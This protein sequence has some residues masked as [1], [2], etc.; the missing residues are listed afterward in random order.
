MEDKFIEINVGG[1]LF[2][3]TYLT[4][5]ATSNYFRRLLDKDNKHK[6]FDMNGAIF[7]DKSPEY[8]TY[9]LSFLRSP[10]S[11]FDIKQF[12]IDNSSFISELEYYQLNTILK[13]KY[14]IFG[15]GEQKGVMN[16]ITSEIQAYYP[17][18]NQWIIINNFPS[19]IKRTGFV[20]N[21]NTA[22]FI[23]GYSGQKALS[24][25]Y[26]YEIDSNFLTK[27]GDL[28]VG[29]TYPKSKILE[30]KLYVV[31]GYISGQKI[32]SKNI[33]IYDLESKKCNIEYQISTEL[34]G[35]GF[36]IYNNK[37]YIFGGWDAKIFD[38]SAECY[39]YDLNTSE[40]IRLSDMNQKRSEINSIIVNDKIYAFGGYD[41]TQF[42]DTIEYYDFEKNQWFMTNIKLIHPQGDFECLLLDKNQV[43][44]VGGRIKCI[45]DNSV[46]SDLIQIIDLETQTITCESLP[47]KYDGLRMIKVF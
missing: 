14:I 44:I 38:K 15:G 1:K 33:Y 42:L 32:C 39:C 27:I 16:E 29:V 22:Y 35:C 23:G 17:I 13:P 10:L 46:L 4:L 43:G 7:I 45:K 37:L 6:I 24:S 9:I 5:T 47:G 18:V 30:N 31:G 41:G 12:P 26:K 21:N 34:V 8:F 19:P 20:L 11:V 28:P 36:E 25:I 40:Y 2:Q 3:T